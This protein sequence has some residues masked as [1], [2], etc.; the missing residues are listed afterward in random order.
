VSLRTAE[1]KLAMCRPYLTH[2]PRLKCRSK[3]NLESHNNTH[4]E[5]L[6]SARLN[7][8]ITNLKLPTL[9]AV[10]KRLKA[11]RVHEPPPAASNTPEVA[12]RILRRCWSSLP[13]SRRSSMR[14]GCWPLRSSLSFDFCQRI[15]CNLCRPLL[16]TRSFGA[17]SICVQITF[18]S[19]K[20]R[21]RDRFCTWL[22]MKSA[23]SHRTAT[24]K[25]ST[26]DTKLGDLMTFTMLGGV[27]R[28]HLPLLGTIA[29]FARRRTPLCY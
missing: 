9:Q 21:M 1:R 16:R 4:I 29:G 22:S 12:S 24:L 7:G 14:S 25:S 17:R 19:L 5:R 10:E 8:D 18:S 2:L 27:E 11:A 15:F 28:L 13:G 23:K 26:D 3:E 6:Y 20:K